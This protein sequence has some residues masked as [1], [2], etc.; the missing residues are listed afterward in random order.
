MFPQVCGLTEV[1]RGTC[2]VLAF[3]HCRAK[4]LSA[5]GRVPPPR[6]SVMARAHPASCAAWAAVP[7]PQMVLGSGGLGS[8]RP[9]APPLG[10]RR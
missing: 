6:S 8:P 5:N 3:Y 1:E 9:W 10:F 7:G 4:S 2:L